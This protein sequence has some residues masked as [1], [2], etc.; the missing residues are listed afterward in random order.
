MHDP[1]VSY[2]AVAGDVYHI[3]PTCPAGR[4]IPSEWRVEGQDE[5]PLCPT[6][7]ARHAARPAQVSPVNGEPDGS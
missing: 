4:L 2:R 7:R 6:C 1:K 5:L 3:D